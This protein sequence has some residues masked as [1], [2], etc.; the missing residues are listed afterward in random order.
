MTKRPLRG[1]SRNRKSTATEVVRAKDPADLLAMIPL[2]LGFHPEQSLVLLTL[3][4]GGT[5]FHARI[6]L[7]GDRA[8]LDVVTGQLVAAATRHGIER[9]VVVSYT[10]LAEA[11]GRAARHLTG[12]LRRAGVRVP[13]TLR[14]DGRRWWCES[15]GC[16][17]E[18]CPAEGTPYDLQS[19]PFTA[20]AVLDG[21]VVLAS[22]AEVQQSLLGTDAG[23][24]GA[25]AAAADRHT[26]RMAAA[27]R[28]PLGLPD[29]AGLRRHLVAEG[30]WLG[31]R[32]RRYL[33]DGERLTADEVGRS[34][35]AM[36]SVQ[37][38]DVAW[39]E[40][41]HH[42]AGRHVEL[43]RDVVRRT[44]TDLLAPPAALLA[45]AAWLD[46][47]GALA[48]CAVDRAQEADPGYSMAGLVATALDR[49]VPPSTWTPIPRT[50]LP[51]FAG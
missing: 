37:V 46:G 43:W 40:M 38:R 8:G 24:I 6:D 16:T 31:A 13:L 20:Q 27:G 3:G 9:A 14:A 21:K 4:G 33:E 11:G 42:D 18:S 22:R 32:V 36:V 5:P 30:H 47:D 23:E 44:P 10:A 29:Q 1:D 12:A 48:W 19:H 51:L 35:V 41:R 17:G 49:A 34:L 26:D 28:H 25:V 50:E 7:P 15:P 39:A 2:I 45:F